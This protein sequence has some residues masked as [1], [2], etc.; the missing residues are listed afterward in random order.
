MYYSPEVPVRHQS[1]PQPSYMMTPITPTSKPAQTPSFPQAQAPVMPHQPDLVGLGVLVDDSQLF[2][3]NYTTSYEF[4][5]NGLMAAFGSMEASPATLFESMP[6]SVPMPEENQCVTAEDV[7]GDDDFDLMMQ[8]SFNA[9]ATVP[10]DHHDIMFDLDFQVMD[11][12]LTPM[13]PPQPVAPIKM[14]FTAPLTPPQTR[15]SKKRL[16][17]SMGPNRV[18]KKQLR[19]L[20]HLIFLVAQQTP[21]AASTKLLSFSECLIKFPIYTANTY[22]FVYE[23]GGDDSATETPHIPHISK[24]LIGKPLKLMKAGLIEFQLNV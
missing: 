12:M 23:N 22:L 8:S 4:D 17:S 20:E 13:M 9:P 18:L 3:N 5:L 6:A 7:L 11:V 16:L 1:Y 10:V 2:Q 21:R 14:E 24:H 15:R 19:Q